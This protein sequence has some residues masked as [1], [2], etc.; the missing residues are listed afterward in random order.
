MTAAADEKRGRSLWWWVA[1]GFLFLGMLWAAMFVVARQ[2]N[3]Q[4]VPLEN[5]GAKP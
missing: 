3:V 1:A 5:K 2:V 4:S